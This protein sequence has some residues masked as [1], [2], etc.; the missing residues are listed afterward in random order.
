MISWLTEIDSLKIRETS[1]IIILRIVPIYDWKFPANI[2]TYEKKVI[3]RRSISYSSEIEIRW[4]S[5]DLSNGLSNYV[6]TIS[7]KYVNYYC[8]VFSMGIIILLNVGRYC[9]SLRHRLEM[10]ARIWCSLIAFEFNKKV[11][12]IWKCSDCSRTP[13]WHDL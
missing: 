13:V 11:K 2:A 9:I 7:P 6:A 1:E 4:K 8:A 10:M 12:I 5:C 3:W